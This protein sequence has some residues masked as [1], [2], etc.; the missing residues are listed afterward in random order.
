MR[1]VPC[2]RLNGQMADNLNEIE[3]WRGRVIANVWYKDVIL[4]IH[5]ETGVV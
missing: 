3:F 1:L 2:V 5:P 4:V